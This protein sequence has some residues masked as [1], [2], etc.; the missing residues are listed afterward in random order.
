MRQVV[1]DTETT[2]LEVREGHRLIEIGCV[3]LIDRKP[4]GRQ[5]H[6]YINPGR[7]IDEEAEAV[8]G[9]T[10][11]F[12]ADKPDFASVKEDIVEFLQD[13]EL[14]IHN[15][16]FDVGF[17]DAEFKRA[18]ERKRTQD[19][20]TI[21]DSLALARTKYP[22]QKNSLDALCKRLGI[23]NSARTLHGALL[24]AEILAEVYLAL[25]GGQ[26]SLG[27]DAP[28]ERAPT[29]NRESEMR[30]VQRPASLRVTEPNEAELNAHEQMLKKLASES[31]EAR[32]W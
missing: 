23:D 32:H 2:G 16:A 26:A 4:T 17:L 18:Q 1:L 27:L 30:R 13:A 6:H 14:I 28:E 7:T 19:F 5:L 3:E 11:E 21:T 29:E 24:D 15:A 9:I 20:C 10:L 12:L 22:G 25:T 31:G 8:H